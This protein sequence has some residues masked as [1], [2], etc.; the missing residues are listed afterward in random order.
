MSVV[1]PLGPHLEHLSAQLEALA[2]QD[3]EAGFEL[4]LSCNGIPVPHRSELQLPAVL[5]A[6]FVDSS[7]VAGPSH[8]RNVGWRSATGDMILFC[9]A[10]D[11]VS[12]GWVSS[13]ISQLRTTDLAGGALDFARLN[14]DGLGS[15]GRIAVGGLP[16][17]FSHHEFVPS[18]N[19]G[20]R[21]DVLERLGGFD[22]EL[23]RS[24]DVDF[25]WR[26]IDAGYRVAFATAAIVHCRRRETF[27]TLF[28]QA[29]EDAANDPALLR[30]HAHTGARW[31]VADYLREATGVAMAA[32]QS[33]FGF[34]P[35]LATRL[36]RFTGH[37][38]HPSMLWMRG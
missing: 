38:L 13:M 2:T 36:G 35:K 27:A 33:P 12:R 37:L 14:H 11:V 31:K 30:R 23:R 6:R 17:K 25:S 8:A 9:D 29:R 10:D 15:W 1:I 26:A 24:E 32:V 16:S 18:G 19:L 21:R 34:A 20:V 5:N 3:F 22:E 28:A 4:V 7:S